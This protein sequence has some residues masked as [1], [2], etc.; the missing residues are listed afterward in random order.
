MCEH[1]S[2]FG[3]C[4]RDG[5]NK[6]FYNSDIWAQPGLAFNSRS[7]R[8]KT[9]KKFAFLAKRAS[10]ELKTWTLQQAE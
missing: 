3:R 4:V 2:L 10:L 9:M 6:K 7:G 1:S 8:K 5:G